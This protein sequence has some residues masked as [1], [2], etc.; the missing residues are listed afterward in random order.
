[1]K[2]S[3]LDEEA[4]ISTLFF[5]AQILMAGSI[6][7]PGDVVSGA[8]IGSHDVENITGS[9]FAYFF[10]GA[11]Q[12]HR[13]TQSFCIEYGSSF[14]TFRCNFYITHFFL[15]VKYQFHLSILS[16]KKDS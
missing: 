16:M 14:D 9:K 8:W 5:F 6:T 11:Q 7:P 4:N 12:R 13:T 2:L 3:F 15:L 1:M 10:F